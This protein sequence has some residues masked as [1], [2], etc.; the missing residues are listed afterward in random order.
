MTF[1][2]PSVADFAAVE[3]ALVDAFRHVQA[4]ARDGEAIVFV[5]SQEDLLG[6]RDVPSAILANSLLS[7][8][9][10]LATEGHQANAI[11]VGAE[12]DATDL[13]HWL[14]LLEEGRGVSGELVRVHAKHVGKI[15]V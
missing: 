6:Q 15:Q 4:A 9:R 10:T 3:A 8:M 13:Q 14:A 5:L 11:A 1:T 2:V 12:T 7:G